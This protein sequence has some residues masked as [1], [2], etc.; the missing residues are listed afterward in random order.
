MTVA[1]PGRR[2]SAVSPSPLTAA[3]A[4]QTLVIFAIRTQRIPFFRSR[5]SVPLL[6]AALAVVAVGAAP[7]AGPG[8]PPSHASPRRPLHH[9]P[10]TAV[11]TAIGPKDP[12]RRDL[13]P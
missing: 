1:V 5:P 11:A 7:A 2:Q 3:A 6:L 8:P 12:R 9:P 13:G 4:T 10:P